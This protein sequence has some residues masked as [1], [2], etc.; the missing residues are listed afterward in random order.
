MIFTATETNSGRLP[1][2]RSISIIMG[3]VISLALR[4]CKCSLRVR[5]N[6]S[7]TVVERGGISVRRTVLVLTCPFEATSTRMK[8][9]SSRYTASKR[10]TVMLEALGLM[11]KAV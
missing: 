6:R 10:R 5:A 3:R 8:V 11:A 2:A 1:M 4:F 7:V 9:L